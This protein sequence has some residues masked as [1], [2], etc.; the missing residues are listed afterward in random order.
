MLIPGRLA[1]SGRNLELPER[2]GRRKQRGWRIRLARLCC[3]DALGVVDEECFDSIFSF[4]DLLGRSD[5]PEFLIGS[6]GR[7]GRA[8][9]SRNDD[10][11]SAIA[12]S[13]LQV[14]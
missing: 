8:Q 10:S 4:L 14:H 7:F 13:E 12:W 2:N 11:I 5:A 3:P 1:N 6:V 9:S